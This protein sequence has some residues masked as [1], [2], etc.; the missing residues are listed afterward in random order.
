MN[1]RGTFTMSGVKGTLIW[2]S[3]EEMGIIMGRDLRITEIRGSIKSDVYAEGLVFGYILLK[4][5][6]IYGENQYDI[7]TNMKQNN[8][9][10]ISEIHQ[11]H[12]A[13]NLIEKMLN[14]TP[15]TRI[16]SEEVVNQLEAINIKLS[17]KEKKLHQLSTCPITDCR[18]N[19]ESLM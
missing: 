3:P 12:L 14:N 13:R 11:K 4:G 8:P 5:R 15:D 2:F 7:V 10:N 16:T 9:A 17:K 18:N 19:I 1:E 6:H